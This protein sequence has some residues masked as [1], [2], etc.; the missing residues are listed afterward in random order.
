[1]S[2][3]ESPTLVNRNAKRA[4]GVATRK[5]AASAMTDPAPAAMP[6]SATTIG[7]GH[8]RIARMTSP[9]IRVNSSSS[10]EPSLSVSPM[11][12]LTSPP[13]Q[14]ARPSPRSTST[15]ASPRWGSSAS[16][17]S[18]SA[19]ASE[20]RALSLSGRS[21]VTVAPPSAQANRKCRQPSVNGADPRNGL[22]ARLPPDASSQIITTYCGLLTVV[23]ESEYWYASSFRKP[24]HSRKEML[25]MRLSPSAHVDTFCR[26]HLPPLDRW[27][28]LH[29]DLPEL[30]QE[31]LGAVQPRWVDQLG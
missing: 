29:F 5:S 17:S 26:D 3:P 19:Y 7:I 16:R 12:S 23:K 31:F 20:V 10:C 15:R 24:A 22:I 27:P 21:R 2:A 11:I 13:E 6:C 30:V 1:M 18:R 28:D 14:N 8:S 4:A 9:V 25:A